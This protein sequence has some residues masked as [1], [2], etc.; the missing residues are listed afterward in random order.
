MPAASRKDG[1]VTAAEAEALLAPLGVFEAVALAVSGGSDS[2]ALMRL[3]AEWAG[4]RRSP[5][6]LAVLTVDHGLRTESAEEAR[7]VVGWARACGLAAEVLTWTGDKPST[8]AHS[9]VS[10]RSCT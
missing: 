1:P 6:R 10:W 3:V 8:R 5:P 4:A 9:L 2:I 7:C